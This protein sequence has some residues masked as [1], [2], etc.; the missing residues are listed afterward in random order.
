MRYR[1]E[2]TED[3]EDLVIPGGSKI[4]GVPFD[5]YICPDTFLKTGPMESSLLAR[6]EKKTNADDRDVPGFKELIDSAN[7][8]L[9]ELDPESQVSILINSPGDLTSSALNLLAVLEMITIPDRVHVVWKV[10]DLKEGV[11]GTACVSDLLYF[12]RNRVDFGK[13][14]K[15]QESF[16]IVEN[17]CKNATMAARFFKVIEHESGK[18]LRKSSTSVDDP[19]RHR[20]RTF[21]NF[22]TGHNYETFL[23]QD[24]GPPTQDAQDLVAANSQASE[25]DEIP[26]ERLKR[27]HTFLLS[28]KED[29]IRRKDEAMKSKGCIG[30]EWFTKNQILK[31]KSRG[32]WQNRNDAISPHKKRTSENFDSLL[33]KVTKSARSKK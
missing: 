2:L 29:S 17:D 22:N 5:C 31:A 3:S 1:S 9:L 7:V 26:L 32:P 30:E 15:D 25:T 33:T 10:P 6:A 19:Y 13:F 23:S 12:L 18:A 20:T 14:R 4:D 24:N 16:A 11:G 21:S 27:T 8:A 28:W